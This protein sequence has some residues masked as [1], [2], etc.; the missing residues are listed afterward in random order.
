MC[1]SHAL[2]LCILLP[3][4][5]TYIHPQSTHIHTDVAMCKKGTYCVEKRHNENGLSRDKELWKDGYRRQ[6]KAKVLRGT[7]PAYFTAAIGA[8]CSDVNAKIDFKKDKDGISKM[9][10]IPNGTPT[11]W[12]TIAPYKKHTFS[13]STGFAVHLLWQIMTVSRWCG[14][15]SVTTSRNSIICTFTR[16]P[17][18]TWRE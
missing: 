18:N 17:P 6:W 5:H 11:V 1:V 8:V 4:I 13:E 14:C 2:I 16:A 3:H 7:D 9:S 12:K 10:H 15:V